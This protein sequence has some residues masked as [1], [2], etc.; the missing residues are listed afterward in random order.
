VLPFLP[1]IAEVLRETIEEIIC[2][3][4]ISRLTPVAT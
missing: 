3:A 4:N 1:Q 2:L